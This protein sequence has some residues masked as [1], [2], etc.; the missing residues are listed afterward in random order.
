MEFRY[1]DK[2]W[3]MSLQHLMKN[4]DGLWKSEK[5]GTFILSKWTVHEE[6]IETSWMS[7]HIDIQDNCKYV[8]VEGVISHGHGGGRGRIPISY[9]YEIDHAGI[10]RRLRTRYHGNLKDGAYIKNVEV[11]WERTVEVPA[12]SQ[13]EP[14]VTSEEEK[15][16]SVSQ[17]FGEVGTRY[18][19]LKLKVTF[20][21][22]FETAYGYSYLNKMEDEKG[23]VFVWFSANCLNEGMTYTMNGTV[24]DH[25]EYNEVKQTVLTRCMKVKEVV[26]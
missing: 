21:T 22:G 9:T 26:Q 1:D 25:S 16:V 17:W 15:V 2:E 3:F 24:K 19:D 18:K 8:L 13:V 5:Q 7:K 11:D 4:N 14:E 6:F 10:K 12:P 23:N 20:T